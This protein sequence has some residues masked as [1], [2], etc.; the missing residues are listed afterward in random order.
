MV[1]DGSESALTGLDTRAL[2]SRMHD[3]LDELAAARG[4]LERLPAVMVELGSD[5]DLDATL[6]RIVVAAMALTSARYGALAVRD[7]D[8]ALASFVHVG[9]DAE[10]IRRIGRL[11]VGKG[12]T[13]VS[14]VQT[15][16][17]RLDDLTTH[18]AAVGFP[19]HHPMMYALLS[20]PI[21]IQKT[22]FGNLYLTHDQP[23]QLFTE[24]DEA[25]VGALA[26]AAAVAVDN[27]R[28]AERLRASLRWIEAS[29]DIT[30]ALLSDAATQPRPL[31]VIAE[32]VC[33]LAEAEQAIVVAPTDG[34][35]PSAEVD[36]LTVAA[37]AGLHAGQVL[38]QQISVDG[39]TTGSVFRSGAPV[40]TESFYF[41][42]PGFADAGQRPTIVVPLCVDGETLG[43]LAVARNQDRPAFDDSD[44]DLVYDFAHRAAVALVVAVGRQSVRERDILAD[45]ER[46]A[47]DLHDHVIQQLFAAG[48][49]LQGTIALTRSPEVIAR[50]DHTVD[51]LQDV[52]AEI[53]ATIFR[54]KSRSAL[55]SGFRQRMQ[56]LVGRLTENRDI[57]TTVQVHGPMMVLDHELAEHAEAVIMEAVSNACRHSGATRLTVEVRAAD[58]LSIA[59]TDNGH[60]IPADNHR[61][62]GLANMLDRAHQVGGTCQITSPPQGGTRVHWI[63]PLT[64][65]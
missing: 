31:Q 35:L 49:D 52:I 2:I 9:F 57:V 22:L 62:S 1:G 8:G 13:D 25:V 33:E 40:I 28:T 7:P 23:S 45:R 46:I 11:P 41:P 27:A 50:L 47:H 48:L 10:T 20:V 53:R 6:H 26:S 63:A 15:H 19:E 37:A 56:Q 44:L 42:I 59:V 54:L 65:H 55:D 3:Q 21:I 43:V 14:L 16:S 39:S 34:D 18:P 64:A 29:R 4:Y 12:V 38:D 51:D 61:R 17:L 60:G 30:A 32:R 24:V 5:L 58:E 36:T